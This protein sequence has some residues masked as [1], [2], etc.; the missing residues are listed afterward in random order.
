M[1][2]EIDF[3]HLSATQECDRQTDRW[4]DSLIACVVLQY[5]ASPTNTSHYKLQ[6]SRP[7][8]TLVFPFN[9]TANYSGFNT[10]FCF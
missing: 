1:S 3:N 9:T 2:C 8:L 5:V 6:A 4:T 10:H 7:V